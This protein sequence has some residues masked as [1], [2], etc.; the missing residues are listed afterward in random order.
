MI[1]ESPDNEST[2][3]QHYQLVANALVEKLPDKAWKTAVI[4]PFLLEN[5][6]CI[7]NWHQDLPCLNEKLPSEWIPC[8]SSL[9]MLLFNHPIKEKRIEVVQMTDGMWQ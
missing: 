3:F 7:I 6:L 4:L 1:S 9:C 2:E 8:E 5:C